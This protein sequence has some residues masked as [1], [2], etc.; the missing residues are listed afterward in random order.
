MQY[1]SAGGKT[2]WEKEAVYTG[3]LYQNHFIYIS[4][5]HSK[6]CMK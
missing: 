4:S 6:A 3:P 2:D 5:L 1:Q